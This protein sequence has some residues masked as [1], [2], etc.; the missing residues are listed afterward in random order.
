MFRTFA[1]RPLVIA[2]LALSVT[3][4]GSKTSPTAPSTVEAQ[5]L[6]AESE[7]YAYYYAA[8]DTVDVAWQEAYHR[9]AATMLGVSTNRK[10]GYHK[11][12]SRQDMG[13]H[14][15]NYQTNGFADAAR[16]E[17]HTLWPIDN[18]EVVHLLMSEIGRAPALF[19]EG[20]AVAFQVNPAAGDFSSKFNGLEVHAAARGYLADGTLVL[21]LDRII[22][23]TGFRN[24]ADS[25]LS[26]REAG[27]FIRF[28]V[29]EYGLD[30]VLAFFR[31]AGTYTDGASATRT[32]FERTMGVTFA[33]A[34]AAWLAMLRSR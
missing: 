2:S 6:A 20:I 7:H 30:R 12:R 18:H 31:A 25:V 24:V 11:Y 14:T 33:Q 10:I 22:E 32:R 21:P 19:D 29:D 16:Y 28:L 9:W 27:S 15:G 5:P 26:Y 17:I 4:C 8:G 34:E 23:S 1:A 3:G 13:D